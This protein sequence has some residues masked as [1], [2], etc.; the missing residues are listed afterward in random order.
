MLIALLVFAVGLRWQ[1]RRPEFRLRWDRVMLK[2]P[3]FGDLIIKAD[4]ARFA[5]TL[6]TLVGNGVSLLSALALA[7]STLG[8]T[9]LAHELIAVSDAVRQGRPLTEPLTQS[10]LFPILAVHLTRVGEE[11]GQPDQMLLKMAEIYDEGVRRAVERTL[12]LLVPVL[13]IVLGLPIAGIIG[14][15]LAAILSV[16][17]L[18][19]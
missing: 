3:L 15:I 10:G 11:T 18:P 17:Q 1:L 16:Y 2:V 6:G 5:R 13:A 7:G 9:A 8:N 4:V 19:Y 12:A 14:T